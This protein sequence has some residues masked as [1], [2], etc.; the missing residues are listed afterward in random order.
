MSQRHPAPHSPPFKTATLRLR[1]AAFA[2]YTAALFTATHIPLQGGVQVKVSDK[3][4][5]LLAYAP[6][7]W[8]AALTLE[9]TRHARQPPPL[10]ATALSARVL[11]VLFAALTFYA[12]LDELLQIPVGRDGDPLDWLADVAG[13]TCGL[14]AYLITDR[15]RRL[16]QRST[17]P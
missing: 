17:L 14:L 16:Y 13:L 9:T 12:A 10:A 1:R 5:H 15:A 8:L 11:A 3:I 4:I 6:L 2:V 7:F